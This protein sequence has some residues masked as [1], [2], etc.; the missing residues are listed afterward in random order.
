M[1]VLSWAP[2]FWE[3]GCIYGILYLR[4]TKNACHFCI[5]CEIW[6]VKD[7][8]FFQKQELQCMIILQRHVFQALS[9]LPAHDETL[10]SINLEILFGRWLLW[11]GIMQ[12]LAENKKGQDK[13]VVRLETVSWN[14][15]KPQQNHLDSV[16]SIWLRLSWRKMT[17]INGEKSYG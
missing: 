8:F 11:P 10:T 4:Q 5:L 3:R 12:N 9:Y 15:T 2:A 6:K 7:G 14:W 16:K 13:V 1:D 17:W